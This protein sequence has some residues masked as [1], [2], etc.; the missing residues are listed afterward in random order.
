V[1]INVP[2]KIVYVTHKFSLI[3]AS[4][5]KCKLDW[6]GFSSRIEKDA[7]AAQTKSHTTVMSNMSNYVESTFIISSLFGQDNA[8]KVK[9]MLR[10]K[11]SKEQVLHS[12]TH[13]PSKTMKIDHDPRR[14]SAST[15]NNF[16]QESGFD[17][18]VTADGQKEGIWSYIDDEDDIEENSVKLQWHIILSGVCWVI[19]MFHL[20]GGKWEYLKYTAFLS[21]VLGVPKIAMKALMAMRRRQFDTNCMMLFATVGAIALQEYSEA[22]AVA[23]LFSISDWLEALSTSRARNALSAIV[24][25][26]PER[27][28]LMNPATG[29]FV[30]VPAVSVRIGSIVSFRT[31]DKIPCD[32]IV[33][34]GESVVDESSLT[35]ESRP[36]Q[37]LRG[38]QVSGGTVNAGLSQLLIRTS[39]TTDDSAVAR[40][41]RLVEDAQANRSPTEKMIDNFAKRYT[42][43]VVLLALCMCTFPWISGHETGREWTKIGLVTVVIACPCALIISTPVTYVAGL[44]AAAQRGIVVKG[45]AHLESLGR[46]GTIAFDKTGTLTEGNFKLLHLKTWGESTRVEALRCLHA[47][48][49]HA[50]HPLAAAIISAA[51]AENATSPSSWNTTSLDNLEGE[52]VTALINGERIYVGNLRLFNRLGLMNGVPKKE[53]DTARGWMREGCTV[54]FMSVEGRGIIC[55][56]CVT[57][58][59]REEARE[60]IASFLK[61]GIDVNMLTGDNARAAMSIGQ[62]LGLE[63]RQIRSELLPHE[64][65]ELVEQFIADGG[66][67]TAKKSCSGRKK[68]LVLMCGDGVNDAPALAISDVGVAMGAG[69]ALAMETADITLLDSNLHKLLKVVKLGKRTNRIIIENIIFSFLAKV[70]V[71]GFTF[72]GYSSLWAA[73]GSDVGAMLIVTANGMKLLPSKKSVRSGSGYD[74]HE[75]QGKDA[76]GVSFP[77]VIPN[78]SLRVLDEENP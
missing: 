65:L 25:L 45:G 59:V 73:I 41:I 61:L 57:D 54:G 28:K 76:P 62:S 72:A 12:E 56:Y 71:M 69:A 58:A 74:S 64:K 27:A 31:G 23:F 11:F 60:V 63:E 39:S 14:V 1:S 19:S 4:Q 70:V 75:V 22:A 10:E 29:E 24:Q 6:E 50:S 43:V 15:L 49:A 51:K 3:T 53:L 55:S 67:A 32:G 13:I 68:D 66:D 47:M 20:I 48:E 18:C 46:V 9:E 78:V 2:N 38:S 36:V 17:T 5:I 21:V 44:A 35:G 34:E 52:G 8:T 77:V 42:P 37:K 30:F 26:R 40:L 33:V 16:L 7:S